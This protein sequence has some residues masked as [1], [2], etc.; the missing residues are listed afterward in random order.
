MRATLARARSVLLGHHRVRS[1]T[2]ATVKS[3]AHS[4]VTQGLRPATVNNELGILRAA[5]NRARKHGEVAQ[6]PH[7]PSLPVDNVRRGFVEPEDFSVIAARL[8]GVY[9]DVAE[10]AYLAARRLGEVVGLPWAWVD[11]GANEF[12][13]PRTKN[14]QPLTLPLSPELWAI[15]DR[16]W[17]ARRVGEWLS[18]WGFHTGRR[19][20]GHASKD[21]VERHWKEATTAAGFPGIVPHDLRRSGVRNLIRA[22]VHQHVAMQISGHRSEAMFRRY[23]I[24]SK[25]DQLEALRKVADYT[26]A[27]QKRIDG[28]DQRTKRGQCVGRAGEGREH[29]GITCLDGFPGA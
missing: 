26:R 7:V 17:R 23:D 3:Y 18:P 5:L 14:D 20:R 11:R 25:D 12:R 27:R 16:R 21:S 6:V 28:Q 22:G 9:R 8:D 19:R 2:T 13:W 1:L 15:V 29:I 24:T 10:F 4:R